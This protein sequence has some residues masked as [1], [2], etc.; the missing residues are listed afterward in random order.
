MID[1]V[2]CSYAF[3]C[4]HLEVEVEVEVWVGRGAGEGWGEEGAVQCRE[5]GGGGTDCIGCLCIYENEMKFGEFI[6][7][8]CL[9]RLPSNYGCWP[10]CLWLCI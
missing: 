4:L 2:D 8:T 6:I 7:R 1:E 3:W 5:R 9:S 10:A